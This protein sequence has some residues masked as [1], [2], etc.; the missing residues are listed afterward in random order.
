M[1]L[2]STLQPIYALME[3]DLRADADA[4][5]APEQRVVSWSKC[6]N[7]YERFT[8]VPRRASLSSEQS[9]EAI[10]LE[11][12]QTAKEFSSQRNK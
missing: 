9:G 3:R 7:W 5:D 6:P 12:R 10:H 2:Q 1:L 11:P 4:R 8:D